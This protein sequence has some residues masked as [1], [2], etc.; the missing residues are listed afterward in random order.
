MSAQGTNE[1][2]EIVWN[3]PNNNGVDH[4]SSARKSRLFC[5][6]FCSDTLILLEFCSVS[7][8]IFGTYLFSQT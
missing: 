2:A 1:I 5:S 3:N 4:A 6:K 7:E 8:K